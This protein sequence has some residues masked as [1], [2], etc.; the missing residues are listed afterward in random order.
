MFKRLIAFITLLLTLTVCLTSYAKLSPQ[1][2]EQLKQQARDGDAS[3][4]LQLGNHASVNNNYKQAFH[5]YTQL[6]KQNDSKYKSDGYNTL[7]LMYLNGQGPAS[8]DFVQAQKYFQKAIKLGQKQAYANL[9]ILYDHG[10]YGIKQDKTKAE[11]YYKKAAKAGDA[12]SKF[13]LGNLYANRK[14]YKKAFHWYHQSAKQYYLSGMLQT[15]LSYSL[16]KGV[17]KDKIQACKW[18]KVALKVYPHYQEGQKMLQSVQNELDIY[19]QR[20]C[21]KTV[22]H[23]LQSHNVPRKSEFKARLEL[24]S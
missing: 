12:S 1:R 2:F 5:W 6:T 7:G 4:Q 19:Q 22:K 3:A 14:Q 13:N 17:N 11:K 9:A 18:L 20:A 15:A 21:N 23:Y 16:G 24:K 8:K 10:G